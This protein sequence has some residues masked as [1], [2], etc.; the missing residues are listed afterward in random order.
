M[1]PVTLIVGALAAGALKG[2]GN[3]SS[4]AVQDAY[5]RLKSLVSSQF[6]RSPTALTVLAEHESDPEAFGAAMTSHVRACGLTQDLSVIAAAQRLMALVDTSGT[7]SGKYIV[8]LRGAQGSQVG[9]R[10]T[11]EN[12]FGAPPSG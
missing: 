3:A 8:D 7:Q 4:A 5:V 10:N 6:A 1:D 11:Q 9:D 2:V 12:T